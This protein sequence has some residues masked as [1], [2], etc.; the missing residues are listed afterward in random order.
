MANTRSKFFQSVKNSGTN[1]LIM[2]QF[3]DQFST[4]YNI[5]GNYDNL[6]VATNNDNNQ[7]SFTITTP[8]PEIANDIAFN[9]Y[10]RNNI[11]IY[12]KKFNINAKQITDNTLKININ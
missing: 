3:F 6:E 7:L 10:N 8:S 4:L 12:G 9:I 11:D 5:I 2:T 1:P